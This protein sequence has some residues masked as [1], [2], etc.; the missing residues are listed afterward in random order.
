MLEVVNIWPPAPVEGLPLRPPA[1]AMIALKPSAVSP[2]GT[3]ATSPTTTHKATAHRPA[4][5][6]RRSPALDDPL[7]PTRSSARPAYQRRGLPLRQHQL[8]C[9]PR[10]PRQSPEDSKLRCR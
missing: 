3:S 8:R 4:P 6:P 10:R 7:M 5:P 1:I 9:R 2:I